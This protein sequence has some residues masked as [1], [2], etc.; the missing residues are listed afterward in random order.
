MF[1]WINSKPDAK[2]LQKII[3]HLNKKWYFILA[4]QGKLWYKLYRK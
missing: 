4:V 3:F 2:I 1:Q